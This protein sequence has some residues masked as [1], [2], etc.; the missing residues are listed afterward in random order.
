MLTI[1]HNDISLH[2]SDEGPEDGPAI[3]FSNSLGTDFRTWDEVVTAL[4]AQLRIIRYDK[5]GHGL[6]DCPE[7]AWGVEEHVADLECILD[8]LEVSNAVLCGL[9]VGGL[10]VQ[11]LAA[12]RPDLAKAL[13]LCDTGAKIGTEALWNDRIAA[14]EAG[15]IAVLADSILE[16]WF[17][18]DFRANEPNMPVWRNMLIRT[19]AHGYMSTARGIRDTDYTESTKGLT[20]PAMA[21]CG[22]EDGATPPD[23]VRATAA[24]IEGCRFELIE[25]SGH[26]PCVDNPEITA[27]LL[28]GFLAEIGH[29]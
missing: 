23:L 25:G 15:G 8:D 16:R 18:A 1:S 14:I 10:I 29:V 21:I 13:V 5:R 7:G 6:S 22:S 4:P 24:L 2:V 28:T 26:L 11:G 9:S 3:V 19:P 27:A 17:S 20:L 12:R